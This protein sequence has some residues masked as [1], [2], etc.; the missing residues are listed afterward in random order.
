MKGLKY[1]HLQNS[2]GQNLSM[3]VLI[4]LFRHEF[5]KENAQASKAWFLPVEGPLDT[6]A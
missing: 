2:I 5:E 3:A 6:Q 1:C 4:L